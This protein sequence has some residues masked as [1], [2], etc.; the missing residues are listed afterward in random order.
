MYRATY[1]E[2]FEERRSGAGPT[3]RT[4]LKTATTKGGKKNG[5]VPYGRLRA[6]SRRYQ[7]RKKDGALKGRRYDR[8]FE[9][10][11]RCIVPLQGQ[12]R[13]ASAAVWSYRKKG[14][15]TRHLQ[16]AERKMA[17]Y[18]TAGSGQRSRRYKRRKEGWRPKGTPLR[19]Q[20][21]REGTMYR[22]PTRANSR[23]GRG[24]VVLQKNGSE[25]PPLQG[26]TERW[27]RT[28]RQASG[29]EVAATKGG[30]TD[31]P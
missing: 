1:E 27:R 14:L 7:R 2:K 17:T 12:I 29:Q 18:P 3:E 11:A 6:R 26:P 5:D 23:S 21:Q 25:D 20:I 19:P 28:L 8:K 10:R 9:E 15:K 13:R 4:G 31:A 22:A 16:R 24:G 30:K